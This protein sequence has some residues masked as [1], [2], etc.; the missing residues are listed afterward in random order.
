LQVALDATSDVHILGSK[1]AQLIAATGAGGENNLAVGVSCSD[2]DVDVAP[3]GWILVK[4]IGGAYVD[5]TIAAGE[6]VTLSSTGGDI[7]GWVQVA[8]GS[9][10]AVADLVDEKVI[11]QCVIRDASAGMATF[12]FDFV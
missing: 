6:M 9:S 1:Y 10:T 8:G 12:Y 11:G 4:G 2:M 5:G 7:A 3:Y